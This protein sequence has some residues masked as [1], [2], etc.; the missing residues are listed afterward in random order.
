M[1]GKRESNKKK[2]ERV[3][4]REVRKVEDKKAISWAADEKEDW[5]REEEMELDHWKIKGMVPK[6]F[7]K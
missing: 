1:C 7:H 4:P 6:K 5:E 3:K 2:W